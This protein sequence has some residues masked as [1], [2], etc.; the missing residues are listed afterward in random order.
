MSSE[1]TFKIY[2]GGLASN[3]DENAFELAFAKFGR[4]MEGIQHTI[5]WSFNVIS[6]FSLLAFYSTW[7]M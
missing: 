7:Y 2:V 3:V 1:P 5:H 6:L 4:I